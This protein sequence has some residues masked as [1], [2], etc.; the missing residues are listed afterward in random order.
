[1]VIRPK[2]PRLVVWD[3]DGPV[4]DSMPHSKMVLTLLCKERG[5][6]F[7]EETWQQFV[8][9]WGLKGADLITTVLGLS[10]EAAT[11]MYKEWSDQEKIN[12][13]YL[14]PGVDR[15]L[16]DLRERG[17]KNSILTSRPGSA[18]ELSINNLGVRNQFAHISTTCTTAYHKPDK[19]AFDETFAFFNTGLGDSEATAKERIDE[20]DTIFIGDTMIDI[21]AG[22]ARGITTFIVRTGPY[23]FK[24]PPDFDPR[25]LLSSAVDLVPKLYELG[26]PM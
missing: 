23:E 4:C 16:Q 22:K 26:Y 2:R 17:I 3:W 14:V 8:S 21:A 24:D 13:C 7:T 9:H 6:P 25:F 18:L 10:H 12:P 1:M 11:L 15:T 5:I 19:R 20:S